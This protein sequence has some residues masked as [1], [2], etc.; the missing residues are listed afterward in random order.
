MN[1][2]LFAKLI[3]YEDPIPLF[4]LHPSKN[5]CIQALDSARKKR[6]KIVGIL[7]DGFEDQFIAL[8][9]A[10][11]VGKSHLASPGELISMKKREFKQLIRLLMMEQEK[12]APIVVVCRL[13]RSATEVVL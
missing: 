12:K 4:S 1:T 10:I 11:E 8:L 7:C 6:F 9:A 3:G 5:S 13:K 2:Q